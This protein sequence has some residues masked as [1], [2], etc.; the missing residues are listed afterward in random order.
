MGLLDSLVGAAA[1]AAFGGSSNQAQAQ[2]GASGLGGIDPQ[3]LMG[4]VGML[5]NQGGGLSGI[6]G[7]LQQGGLGV[8]RIRLGDEARVDSQAAEDLVEQPKRPAINVV[9]A[10]D[11]IPGRKQVQHPVH[12]GE[13]GSEGKRMPGPLERRQ[14]FLVRRA[15]GIVGPRVVVALVLS[16]GF[17]GVR[18]R[19]EDRGHHGAGHPFRRLPRVDRPGAEPGGRRLVV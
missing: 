13:A 5:M 12:G 11:M 16:G 10:E 8:Q 14:A 15:R 19:L 3:I 9:A 6:L 2:S 18:A 7:K 17:L 1:N 4:I